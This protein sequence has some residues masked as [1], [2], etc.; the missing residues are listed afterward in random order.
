VGVAHYIALSCDSVFI[1]DNQSW[2][3]VHSYVVDNWVR[4]PIFISLDQML[5]GSRSNNLTKVIMEVVMIGG[6]LPQDQIAKKLICFGVDG[7]NVFQGTK[8][9]VIRQICDNC[10][11]H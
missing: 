4:I 9:S 11:L 6:G 1:F 7:A 2:L 10:A 8:I 5:K 3:Y